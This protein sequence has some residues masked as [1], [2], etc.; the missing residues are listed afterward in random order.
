MYHVLYQEYDD[1][2]Y[3]YCH[4]IEDLKKFMKKKRLDPDDICLIKGGELIS[5]FDNKH[6]PKEFFKKGKT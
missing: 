5:G 3:Y 4:T 6:M 2:K 1:A